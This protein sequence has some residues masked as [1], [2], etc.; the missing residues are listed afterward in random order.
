MDARRPLEPSDPGALS[1]RPRTR[2]PGPCAPDTRPALLPA[3]PRLP[4]IGLGSHVLETQLEQRKEELGGRPGVLL[5]RISLLVPVRM[6]ENLSY[7][8]PCPPE[9]GQSYTLGT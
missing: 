7:A 2:R 3:A 4:G 9:E 6:S 1:I 8:V 5:L